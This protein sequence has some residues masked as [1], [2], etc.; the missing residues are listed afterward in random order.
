MTVYFSYGNPSIRAHI[1][2]WNRALAVAGTG[3][4]PVISLTDETEQVIGGGD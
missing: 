4:I 1:L 2:A 3:A